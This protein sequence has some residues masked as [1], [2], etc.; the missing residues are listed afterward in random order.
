MSVDEWYDFVDSYREEK[1]GIR[2]CLDEHGACA[3]NDPDLERNE[4]VV[5]LESNSAW[6]CYKQTLKDKGL[7]ETTIS[8]IEEATRDILSNLTTDSSESQTIKGLVYGN[9]QSGKTANMAALIAMAADCGWNMFIVL[10]GTLENLRIQTRT[11]LIEDLT[12]NANRFA[13]HPIDN[14]CKVEQEERRPQNLRLGKTDKERYLIVSLK[15][16]RR[17]ENLVDYL[18]EGNQENRKNMR[19]LII[20]DEADNA[21]QNT[22]KKDRERTRINQLIVNLINNRR[23]NGEQATT[24]F[25]A[26]NYIG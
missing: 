18:L 21:S 11:R 10:S 5:P 13:W 14:P 1:E 8:N 12:L 3:I 2:R 15:N 17:L 25:G 6:Q 20:D 16:T 19:L 7:A 4:I 22:S 24:P 23:S 9:V 26:V